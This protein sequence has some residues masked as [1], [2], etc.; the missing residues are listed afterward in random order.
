MEDYSV[1][2]LELITSADNA[3]HRHEMRSEEG[4][5]RLRR[6]AKYQL[7]RLGAGTHTVKHAAQGE[8][9]ASGRLRSVGKHVQDS[10][11]ATAADAANKARACPG[12]RSGASAENPRTRDKGD[13]KTRGKRDADGGESNSDSDSDSDSE[14]SGDAGGSEDEPSAEGDDDDEESRRPRRR[15]KPRKRRR[16]GGSSS[17]LEQFSKQSSREQR[18]LE[19]WLDKASAS[20][21]AASSSSTPAASASSFTFSAQDLAGASN[22]ISETVAAAEGESP[23]AAGDLADLELALLTDIQRHP[24]VLGSVNTILRRQ[25]LP[26]GQRLWRLLKMFDNLSGCTVDRDSQWPALF[27]ALHHGA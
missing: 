11:D 13:P 17:L 21:G 6:Q 5:Q 15:S 4:A 23:A 2:Q 24:T 14:S 10:R 27:K 1:E 12:R 8:E 25:S 7:E 22:I 16:Q 9:S 3:L 20:P 18:M 26:A 19:R